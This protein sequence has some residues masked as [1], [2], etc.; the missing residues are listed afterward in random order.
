[1]FKDKYNSRDIAKI[2]NM[3]HARVV[4]SIN[5]LI[6]NNE[7]FNVDSY[8]DNYRGKEFEVFLLNETQLISL[9]TRFSKSS[10]RSKIINLFKISQEKVIKLINAIN[11]FDFE[12]DL[13]E[14]FLYAASDQ[15]GNIKIGIS[16]NPEERVKQL[17]CGNAQE[18]S[19][20]FIKKATKQ[21]YLEETEIHNKL[22][23]LKIRS[24]WFSPVCYEKVE[25]IFA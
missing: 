14:R 20:L 4:R 11:E 12:E 18:L 8:V 25:R 24:E 21:K 19:L 6:K 7:I 9:L 10:S 13:P 2:F 5:T 1:M 17:N 16:K 23:D 15:L 22:S 3:Q